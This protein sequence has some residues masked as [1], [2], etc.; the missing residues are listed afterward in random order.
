MSDLLI[1]DSDYPYPQKGD[2]FLR[3][4]GQKVLQTSS[5]IGNW[6]VYAEAYKD[7][8]DRLVDRLVGNPEEDALVCPILF[9]YRHYLELTLKYQAYGIENIA[10]QEIPGKI[11]TKHNLLALWQYIRK[12]CDSTG[13]NFGKEALDTVEHCIVEISELDPI[14]MTFRYSHKLDKQEHTL[15]S[16]IDVENCKVVIEKLKNFFNEIGIAAD[17]QHEWRKEMD[18]W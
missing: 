5:I 8:A 7:A 10:P 12:Y 17:L 15:P 13:F 16:H 1:T 6:L 18:S 4:E 2:S 3:T 11:D 14:S 9:L